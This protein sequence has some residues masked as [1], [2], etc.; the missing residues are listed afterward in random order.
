MLAVN[1]AWKVGYTFFGENHSSEIDY[2]CLRKADALSVRGCCLLEAKAK[3]VQM[4]D[5][6]RPCDHW[7]IQVSL[8]KDAPK[9]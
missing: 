1:I 6:A 7:P 3:E 4:V 5:V 8:P 2:I 9:P